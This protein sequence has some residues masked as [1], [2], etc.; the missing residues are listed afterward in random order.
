[1]RKSVLLGWLLVICF[2][3]IFMACSEKKE[4]TSSFPETALPEPELPAETVFFSPQRLVVS[5]KSQFSLEMKIN[6]VDDVFGISLYVIYDPNFFEYKGT[7][8]GDFFSKDGRQTSSTASDFPP[9]I[10]VFGLTRLDKE[11]SGAVSGSGRIATLAFKSNNQTGE[12]EISFSK[13]VI[14][15]LEEDGSHSFKDIEQR[16]AL[17][18]VK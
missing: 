1:M 10:L 2:S 7:S 14:C 4:E 18:E 3:F 16:A 6:Q 5:P 8:K 17:I 9:G 11:E 13:Q 15:I 12:S